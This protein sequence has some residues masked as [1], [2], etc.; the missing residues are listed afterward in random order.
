MFGT[1]INALTVISTELKKLGNGK[2]Y[3]RIITKAQEKKVHSEKSYIPTYT[4]MVFNADLLIRCNELEIGDK[5]D[6]YCRCKPFL[7]KDTD[8]Q[9]ISYTLI[10]FE[11][12]MYESL[13]T[14]D[15]VVTI[16]QMIITKIKDGETSKGKRCY[17]L[18][19]FTE[20]NDMLVNLN[21]N[22]FNSHVVEKIERMKLQEKSTINFCAT[23][24]PFQRNRNG[25]VYQD[26][27]YIML[28]CEFYEHHSKEETNKPVE[29]QPQ[30]SPNE[31]EW[32]LD[33]FDIFK[34]AFIGKL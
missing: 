11:K 7:N 26:Y 14:T 12:S 25:K 16:R 20:Y 27:S 22:A 4:L 34:Q 18:N 28:D 19:G 13:T 15:K 1:Q 5:I 3:M 33:K 10:D 24:S 6:A 8:A 29:P 21:V 17:V 31:P 9:D 30:Y 32:S 23:L 2:A